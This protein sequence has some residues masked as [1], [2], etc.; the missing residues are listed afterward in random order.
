MGGA[1]QQSREKINF[2]V[3]EHLNQLFEKMKHLYQ[4]LVVL[5]VMTIGSTTIKA[6]LRDVPLSDLQAVSTSIVEGTVTAKETFWNDSHTRIYTLYQIE[7][8]DYLMGSGPTRLEVVQLGGCVDDHCQRLYPGLE[9]GVSTQGVLFL[10]SF[11]DEPLHSDQLLEV[12]SGPLGF[13]QF[14][15]IDGREVG[16][17]ALRIFDLNQ[18]VYLPIAGRPRRSEQIHLPPTSRAAPSIDSLFPDTV[19][20]GVND[21]LTIVGTEF[22]ATKGKVWFQNA[23]EPT[24]IYMHGENPD[25]VVWTD[26]L[27]RVIVPTEGSLDSM[28][29]GAAGTGPIRVEATDGM[30]NTS[31]M[32]IVVPYGLKTFRVGYDSTLKTIILTAPLNNAGGGYTFRYD[33][34]F[35]DSADAVMVFE[36]SMRD[37]RCAS[38]INWTVGPDTTINRIASDSICVVFWDSLPPGVIGQTMVDNSFCKDETSGIFYYHVVEIDMKFSRNANFHYDTIAPPAANQDDFYSITL[39]ELGHGHLLQHINR[40][41]FLMHYEITLGTTI[42]NI[43]PEMLTGANRAIDTSTVN[44]HLNCFMPHVPVPPGNCNTL[45]SRRTQRQFLSAFEVY[46]NPATDHIRVRI[47]AAQPS[48]KV[49]VQLIDVYGQVLQT[50]SVRLQVA[51]ATEL[52]LEANELADGYYLVRISNEGGSSTKPIIIQH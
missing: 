26:T 13:I 47:E 31:P 23:D 28:G 39:H 5:L 38:G 42:R 17:N 32:P 50:R 49:D 41:G 11:V 15:N 9:M 37:W 45:N 4:T 36:K 19:A 52:D 12:V 24:G 48:C 29:R 44:H 25:L 34:A 46:P 43:H 7:A 27:I 21:T 1:V 8:S 10:R 20:A 16:A 30:I 22:G 35:A 14:H 18:E 51:A 33:T 2:F 6:Q 3:E 40:P